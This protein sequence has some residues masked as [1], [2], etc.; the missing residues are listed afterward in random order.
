MLHIP[1]WVVVQFEIK[2]KSKSKLFYDL[3]SVG[4]ICLPVKPHLGDKS[5]FLL[6]SDSWRFVDVGHRL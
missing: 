2:S 1:A 5:R 4:K 3:W 6:L